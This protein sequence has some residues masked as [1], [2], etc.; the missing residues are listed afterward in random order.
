MLLFG[1]KGSRN[2]EFGYKYAEFEGHQDILVKM[3]K[4]QLEIQV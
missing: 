1:E 3:P 2:N 4:K